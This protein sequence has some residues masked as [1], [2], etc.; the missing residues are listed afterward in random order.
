[1][2]NSKLINTLK[3]LTA[4]EL[5]GIEELLETNLLLK[6]SYKQECVN[7]FAYLKRY[8]PD[9]QQED[10]KKEI[11]LKQ[12]FPK[13]AKINRLEKTMTAL[14]QVVEYYIIHFLKKGKFFE[15]ANEL[16]LASFYR[17]RKQFTRSETAYKKAVSSL[18]DSDNTIDT[19]YYYW[20]SLLAEEAV[21]FDDIRGV[22]NK[23]NILKKFDQMN[24]YAV[25]KLLEQLCKTVLKR[26]YFEPNEL[27]FFNQLNDI[28]ASQEICQSNVLIR[29][30]QLELKMFSAYLED[31]FV[32]IYEEYLKVFLANTHR[33]DTDIVYSFASRER[34]CLVY[35]YTKQPNE[36]N[37][38]YLFDTYKRHLE[39]GALLL[40]GRIHSSAA[41]NIMN[42]SLKLNERSWLKDFL[43]KWKDN[44]GAH[45]DNNEEVKRF[46]YSM[47]YFAEK[48]FSRAEDY[49]L[50]HY[51]NILL[52][53]I[54]RRLKIKILFERNEFNRMFHEIDAF[55][56]YL[57]RN[58]KSQKGLSSAH[59]EW[60]N[61]FITIL[62]KVYALKFR[63]NKND[64]PKLLQR[65]Q[66]TICSDKEWLLQQCQAI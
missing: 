57:F 1:M 55:K 16:S 13:G 25:L 20:K 4:K 58:V 9:F 26:S 36:Q 11:V 50:P 29:L 32:E 14:L 51:D 59:F 53:L 33:F 10:L 24:E 64:K 31:K 54:T 66:T 7:L 37:L 19:E 48:Q 44:F 43:E 45:D 63:K 12:L 65:I 15:V 46:C 52:F 40:N 61:N 6:G 2:I 8:A 23:E 56:I 49:I 62:K 60:N 42:Y 21:A 27:V 22:F 30:H 47:Y 38:R 28:I 35:R 34:T 17:E 39:N 18:N 5:D 41:I 3:I